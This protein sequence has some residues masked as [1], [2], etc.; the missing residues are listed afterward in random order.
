MIRHAHVS[1]QADDPE[2]EGLIRPSDWNAAHVGVPENITL[3]AAPATWTNQP[4]A[5]TELPGTYRSKADLTFADEVRVVV[6]L[7]VGGAAG[8]TVRLQYSTNQT[9]WADL[10]PS[11]SITASGAAASAW[12]AV[13]AGAK[14]DVFLRVLGAGG[15]AVVDPQFRN[16]QLQV[17]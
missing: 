2:A 4:A 12:A 13:P 6:S 1:Q 5:D 3:L 7:A 16:V 9:Q 10:T 14:T 17:R 11:V 8:A 15:N